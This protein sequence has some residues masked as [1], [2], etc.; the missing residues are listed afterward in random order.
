V[1]HFGPIPA[2]PEPP[3]L[4]TV[5]PP[6]KGERRF[7]IRE[8]GQNRIL[9][10]AYRATTREDPDSYALDLLGQI[11]GTGKSSRL[12]RALVDTGL[13]TE[14]YAYNQGHLRDPF[15]FY[16]YAFLAE[17]A[18]PDSVEAA[19]YREIESIQQTPPD[20][21]EL[22]R[23]LKQTKVET[24]FS[25]DQ[26][27]SL[28]FAIGE[29]ESSGGYAFHDTYLES[30]GLVS[31]EM[32]QQAAQRYL[33]ADSRTVGFY[34][35][36]GE[37]G[38]S[39]VGRPGDPSGKWKYRRSPHARNPRLLQGDLE[40]SGTVVAQTETSAAQPQKI[41]LPNG[42]VLL[43]QESHENPTLALRGRLEG[44]LLT[45]PEGKE[46]VASLLAETLPLGT[47]GKDPGVLAELLES[48]GISISFSVDPDG[49]EISAQS[50]SEDFPLLVELLG[51]ILL[52]PRFDPEQIEI[53]RGQ[54]I[55]WL[56]EDQQDT[57]RVAYHRALEEMYGEG[58]PYARFI[59][60]NVASLENLSR[61]DLVAFHR[62]TLQGNRLTL[63]V[64][65]DTNPDEVRRL[66]EEHLSLFPAGEELTLTVPTFRSEQASGEAIR[67]DIPDKSQVD[68]VFVG[69]GVAP[70]SENYEAVA[71]ANVVLGGSFTSR[72][73]GTLR[74]EE[75]LT[76]GAFSWFADRNGSTAWVA[77]LGVNPENVEQ[78]LTGMHREIRELID[79][80]ITEEEAH[81]A[82]EYAAGS[83][84]IRLQSK[85]RVAQTLLNAERFGLGLDY[86]QTRAAKF[87]KPSLDE[88]RQAASL[89][90]DQDRVAV[91]MAGTF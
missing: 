42:I 17:D 33:I 69:R 89:I 1:R 72:L 66:F 63:A 83:F 36:T 76:Y 60:G 32:I 88:I 26:L 84:P 27:T 49:I 9:G 20:P 59:H 18:S 87:R 39:W 90:A 13:A 65:G 16:V 53:A 22:S 15:L 80:P 91:V 29:A 4:V 37:A 46:G 43:V 62:E 68:L 6:Q 40:A 3:G 10:L 74:D 61:D 71:L 41:S 14:V 11:L 81:R 31:P 44:G 75:G 64:V 12:Y 70:S 50:L 82:Q 28:M 24:L 57:Y 21:R 78:A 47:V 85:G 73:N 55:N 8:S 2:G 51:E 52:A 23:V 77:N 34:L 48:H 58:S 35:P 30:L 38:G 67:L 5:E 79:D 45:E 86:I 56:R 25:R 7:V 54:L 19:I